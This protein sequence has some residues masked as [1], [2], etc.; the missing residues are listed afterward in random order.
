MMIICVEMI[1][2][3]RVG[4]DDATNKR[5]IVWDEVRRLLFNRAQKV[6]T[7]AHSQRQI[8]TANGV[9]LVRLVA[10]KLWGIANR[11]VGN[12]S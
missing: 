10:S 6:W 8:A 12:F 4:L 7:I 11:L 1:A 9:M 3:T 5:P 2:N